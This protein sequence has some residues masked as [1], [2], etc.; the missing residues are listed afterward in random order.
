Q[1]TGNSPWG[2][3]YLLQTLALYKLTGNEEYVKLGRDLMDYEITRATKDSSLI[4]HWNVMPYA[5]FRYYTWLRDAKSAWAPPGAEKRYRAM[6]YPIAANPSTDL[7]SESGTH[8]RIWARYCILKA[9]RLFAEQDG[10]PVDPRVVA[11]TDYHQKL[12]EDMGDDDDASS[13]YNWGWFHFPLSIYYNQ[14]DLSPLV[15][16]PG[17]VKVITRYAETISPSGAMPTFGADSGW[18]S[19]GQSMW[20]FEMMA[21]LTR[22]GQ[23]RWQAHRVAEYLYN[24]LYN[25][26]TQYH[27]PADGMKNLFLMA[28]FFA[29]DGITPTPPSGN[30]RCTWRHPMVPVTAEMKKEHP[31]FGDAY[32]IPQGWIPDKM[33]LTT[34]N[35][36]RG[37]WGLVELLPFGGH[38]GSLPG[39]FCAMLHQD[40]VMLAGQGY[41]EQTPQYQNILWIEDLDGLAANPQPVTT[42]V[43]ILTDDAAYTYARVK[44]I[45]YQQLPVTYT[46]DI[47]FSKTGFVVV[48]D[49][50]KFDS[51]M[52]VRLGPCWQTRDI[53]PQCGPNW[54]NTYYEE[55]YVTGLGLGR[56]V[57]SFFNP[58]W[59][60]LVYFSPRPDRKQTVTDTWAENPYRQSPIRMRQEWAGMTA[61]GQEITFTS[62]LLP[63]YPMLAPQ[64]L[65][66][67][68]K[69]A[70]DIPHIETV[71]DDEKLTVLKVVTE[72]DPNN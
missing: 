11:Y 58:P 3:G 8:N 6:F 23:F 52:K 14:G 65:L 9:A 39:N 49:R 61:P 10:K 46:R 15:K 41:Y 55:M 37:L 21:A 43:P 29:D 13:G 68:P 54:F 26:V 16:N 47:L 2:S 50:A 72:S 12:L 28:Y 59:D 63:H 32:M 5:A 66:N 30:S 70:N 7:F 45:A 56:G 53:G 69:E 19:I 48:K 18:P 35:D 38:G 22:N 71:R 25:D 34:G 51:T 67:P 33:I 4:S 44:T 36:P 40:S 64:D 57:Q 20:T 42:E 31:G 17:Y 1:I 24:Y 27:L 60:L 62:V